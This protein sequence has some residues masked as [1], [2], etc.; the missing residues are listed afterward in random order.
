MIYVLGWVVSLGIL[1]RWPRQ[2]ESRGHDRLSSIRA[3]VLILS[4]IASLLV[5]GFLLRK[6]SPQTAVASAV[7]FAAAF[8]AGQ[9]FSLFERSDLLG[10]LLLTTPGVIVGT[11]TRKPLLVLLALATCW[12]AAAVVAL[13]LAHAID[14]AQRLEHSESAVEQ[15]GRDWWP[16]LLGKISPV[17]ATVAIIILLLSP[18]LRFDLPR[19]QSEIPTISRVPQERGLQPQP[20]GTP[21]GSPGMGVNG[22]SNSS[23]GDEG[24]QA[25]TPGG[26][27]GSEP[28]EVTTPQTEGNG[29]AGNGDQRESR[30]NGG[31]N[32]G[33]NSPTQEGNGRSNQKDSNS[34]QSSQPS[35]RGTKT[36]DPEPKTTADGN[37]GPGESTENRFNPNLNLPSGEIRVDDTPVMRIDAPYPWYWRGVAYETYLDGEWRVGTGL[38]T[39]ITNGLIPA[40]FDGA[41]D[42]QKFKGRVQVMDSK[43]DA[44]FTPYRPIAIETDSPRN[45]TL[46][47]HRDAVIS[48]ESGNPAITYTI[49]SLIPDANPDRLRK[50]GEQVPSDFD[51]YLQIPSSI[52]PRVHELVSEIIRDKHGRYEKTIAIIS[53]LR[54]RAIPATRIEPPPPG[55]DPVEHYLFEGGYTGFSNHLASA[56]AIMLRAA[57]IETRVISG[58]VPHTPPDE[59]GFLIR[60]SDA[61]DWVEVFFPGTGWVVFDAGQNPLQK[62]NEISQ[63][64]RLLNWIA[65]NWYWLLAIGAIL[66]VTII[67]ALRA[68]KAKKM[69]T[70]TMTEAQD[71]LAKLEDAVRYQRLA[72][73]TPYEY[74]RV[75]RW[76]L[77]PEDAALAETVL[78]V[79][80][81]SAYS[82]HQVD[83]SRR[84]LALAAVEKIR[85]SE[86]RR[87]GEEKPT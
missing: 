28:G 62:E 65:N 4:G 76:K 36:P 68:R 8:G 44:I 33:G 10:S 15:E 30:Q 54:E 58:Y 49:N 75:L 83:E 41:P 71:L 38:S 14:L 66:T 51:R 57:G 80:S 67:M 48:N 45:P 23:R 32:R 19:F 73:Q 22:D 26:H 64:R 39:P 6:A 40:D 12:L 53:Y 16:S 21:Q 69:K 17:V 34:E 13:T 29:S 63:W 61:H 20:S 56:T 85:K 27:A 42:G 9:A 81:E 60:R 46:I 31:E 18:L 74:A 5:L 3:T 70:P 52:S 43:S 37:S 82:A 86:A 24:L 84:D 77:L 87:R 1:S 35:S 79:V 50:A 78:E 59:A 25:G 7:F 2:K 72:P 55:I 47:L 11:A